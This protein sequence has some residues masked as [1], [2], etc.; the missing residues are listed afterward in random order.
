MNISPTNAIRRLV[1]GTLCTAIYLGL[2]ALPAG[3]AELDRL[4]VTVKYGDL[5]VTRPQ[6]ATI[7]YGRI[8]AAAKKVCLP[9]EAGDVA[10]KMRFDGCI[11]KAISD[12][13]KTI[14]QPE[15]SAF[16]S[17]KR[18]APQAPH[19]VHLSSRQSR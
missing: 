10:A 13:V 11:D 9:L 3:A 19:L 7:L 18:G 2:T 4:S 16:D 14:Q 1:A 17:A 6:G 12:A 15:L 5:D 8:R